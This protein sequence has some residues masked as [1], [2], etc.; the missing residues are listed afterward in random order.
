MVSNSSPA[1]YGFYHG[2]GSDDPAA[3]RA[4]QLATRDFLISKIA[5]R[6]LQSVLDV[7]CGLGLIAIGIAQAIPG[8]N[9][10]GIDVWDDDSL[11]GNS[12]DQARRNAE[13]EGVADQV[14]FET[15]DARNLPFADAAFNLVVS[16]LVYHN[17]AERADRQ[18]AYR[19]VFRVLK[20]GCTFLYSDG[21][22]AEGQRDDLLGAGFALD[23]ECAVPTDEGVYLFQLRRQ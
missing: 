14:R 23:A 5:D 15:G 6:S 12:I 22:W 17:I 11:H 3:N 18:R 8:S 7:G 20:P 9:V 2:Y 21:L 13:I 10:V 16:N 4:R 1:E 19:E